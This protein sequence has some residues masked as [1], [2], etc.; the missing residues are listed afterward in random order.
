MCGGISAHCRKWRVTPRCCGRS[1]RACST[2]H[3]SSPVHEPAPRSR[4]GRVRTPRSMSFSCAITASASTHATR[5]SCSA[6]FSGCTP[7]RSSRAP[8]L[9][10]RAS[11]ASF[12]GTMDSVG[13]RVCPARALSF[14]FRSLFLLLPMNKCIDIL[15]VEDD[16][17]DVLLALTVFRAMGT[18][19]RCEVAN[20]GEDA[21]DFLRSRGRFAQRAPGLPG[22]ILLDLKMPRVNGFDFLHQIKADERLRL[23]PVI[24]LTSSREERDVERAYDLGVNGYVVK[25]IDFGDYRSTLQSLAQYW[26]SVNE[27][28]P[29]LAQHSSMVGIGSAFKKARR[30]FA[31]VRNPWLWPPVPVLIKQF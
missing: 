27:R 7:A 30:N 5:T 4:S 22:L 20:D 6:F 9:G 10:S 19:E 2:T 14:T 16:R 1:S 28:P 24:A 3:S 17:A 15:L 18:A 31:T 25:G 23:I 13:P 21:M 11:A 29:G 12:N 26:G 8:A